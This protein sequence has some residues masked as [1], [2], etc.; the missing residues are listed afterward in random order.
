MSKS[1]TGYKAY[2]KG[3]VCKGF[4]YEE[5]KTYETDKAEC[6]ETG[7]HLC[8]NPLDVLNYYDL[9]D[10]EF[11]EAEAIGKIDKSN[12]G[13][14]KLATTQIKIGAKL[15]LKSF[16]DVAVKCLIEITKSKLKKEKGDSAQLAS[17]GDFA[18]LASSGD[19]AKLASSGYSAK[20]QLNG[21]DSVGAAI[22]LDSKIKGKKGDWITLA[23]WKFYEEKSRF[24]PICVKS[25]QIDGDILKE[26]TWYVL[27]N[28]EFKK[29][30]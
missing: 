2:N 18:Q 15:S 7:F 12:N 16:I 29:V 23:E 5:G 13:D 1:I 30:K 17:S 19:Y 11:S 8:T 22:G 26:D 27:R 9:V 4:Q 24:V 25:A 21:T 20:L 6:C 28:G 14:S 3:M 10:S